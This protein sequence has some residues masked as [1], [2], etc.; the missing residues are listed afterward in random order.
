M[1]GSKLSKRQQKQ[2]SFKSPANEI[3]TPFAKA[4]PAIEP[5]LD[6]LDPAKVYI[7]HI[8][9]FPVDAK[10]QIFLIPVLL[11][12]AI[13]LL[14]LWRI[15]YAVPTYYTLIQTFLG[16]TT[17][18]TV[19][20]E[21]TTRREQFAVLFKRFA[22]FFIDFLVFR[23]MGPWPLTFFFEQP[24]NPVTWR[25][26]LGFKQEEAVVRVSRHWSAEDLMQGVK[27]GEESPFF[28]T[29]ILPAID[30]Q[31]M[32]SKTGYLM[33]NQSWD[34]DFQSMLD[35]HILAKDDKLNLKHIDKLI[36]VNME[37]VGWLAWRW[38]TDN[39]VIEDR[40]KKLVAFKEVLTK[41]GKESLFFRWMEIVEQERDADGS[42]SAGKQQRVMERVKA[43][44]EKECID[45]EEL[46]Q[47][48][49]GF[50]ELPGGA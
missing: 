37:S 30:K 11:N 46:S 42:F 31:F 41:M 32:R 20:V 49:G 18:A 38:E 15:R 13:A 45:F 35:A 33:M 5:L 10:K 6:Q 21:N 16:Y 47:G 39:D 8:D 19:D 3:P 1:S 34:L 44:F 29:R 17:E 43:A 4:P 27:Q 36:L 2:T 24:A 50:Q 9:R 22:M 14:L 23:F 25:L 26:A 7:T 12:A 48:I 28:K 40:R